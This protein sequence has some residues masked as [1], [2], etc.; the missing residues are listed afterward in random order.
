MLLKPTLS[1]HSRGSV[2]AAL[3]AALLLWALCSGCGQRVDSEQLYRDGLQAAASGNRDNLVVC[4]DSL[5]DDDSSAPLKSVLRGHLHCLDNKPRLALLE[6]SLANRDQRTREESWFQAGRLSY[7]AKQYAEALALLRQV[8]E[9]NPDRLEA[10]QLLAAASYDIG[11]MEQAIG[12]LKQVMR[13]RPDDFR[14]W[15]ME[16]SILQDFER[17]GDAEMS[18]RE[19]ASRVPAGSAASDEV[20][21]GWGDCL[22][23]LRKYDAALQAL[24]RARD[25]P[26]VLARRAQAEFALRQFAAA[27]ADAVAAIAQKPLHPD[28]TVVLAQ[29]EEREGLT[30]AAIDRLRQV[31]KA[32]PMEL[33]PL[34]RLADLLA[35]TGRVDESLTFRTRAGEIAE[36]RAT[37]SKLHQAAVRDLTDAD[38]RLQLAETA[39]KLK[40]PQMAAAWYAAALGMA[41]RDARIQDQWQSFLS[42]HPEFAP[43]PPSS[44][45]AA[46]EVTGNSHAAETKQPSDF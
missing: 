5:P 6:F 20:H 8:V 21:A 43:N 42:R 9:W 28:A 39:D 29:I 36:L 17:F 19:A 41:P 45:A 3:P 7:E 33:P 26:D 46:S 32:A 2:S 27:R 16:A 35:A 13:L 38:L 15:H 12:S 22:V 10:H 4:L 44:A 37:F 18:W 25:W 30:D 31:V 23:R 24:S 34:L 1:A 40:Q 11:A 14:P